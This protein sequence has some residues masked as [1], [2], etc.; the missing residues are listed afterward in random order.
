MSKG[1][2]TT[3]I[4]KIENKNKFELL[5][6]VSYPISIQKT[7]IRQTNRHNVRFLSGHSTSMWLLHT[8][9]RKV[10]KKSRCHFHDTTTNTAVHKLSPI[11]IPKIQKQ[12]PWL[13]F[14]S[15]FSDAF[16]LRLTTQSK[17]SWKFPQCVGHLKNKTKISLFYF[18]RFRCEN[19]SVSCQD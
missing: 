6:S 16:Q 2:K 9:F 12:I 3:T 19:C 13:D 10:Q 4:I 8:A 14:S 15:F 7:R 11:A 1:R 17:L 18:L 5:H